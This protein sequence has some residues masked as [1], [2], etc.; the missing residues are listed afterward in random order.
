MTDE[1]TSYLFEE[2]GLNKDDKIIGTIGRLYEQK[3]IKYLFKSFKILLQNVPN[4]NLLIVGDGPLREDLQSRAKALEIQD[5]V[6]FTGVRQDI[7]CLLKMFDVFVLASL[8]EGQPITIMEAMAAGKPVVVTDV[9]GNKE[10][11]NQGKFGLIIPAKD[12]EAQ[13]RAIESLL[14]DQNLAMELGRKAQE[15]AKRDLGHV[16]MVRKYEEVFSKVM[17]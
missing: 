16:S 1:D 14:N 12:P 11:L 3:G 6:I 5:K 7:P 8:W 13:A 17:S 4:A 2:F 10:I 9:G 15:Q